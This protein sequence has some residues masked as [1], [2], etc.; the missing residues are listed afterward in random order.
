[1]LNLHELVRTL[2]RSTEGEG[3]RTYRGCWS[4]GGARARSGLNQVDAAANGDAEERVDGGRW[5][6]E[7]HVARKTMKMKRLRE[8][9]E[10]GPLALFIRRMDKWHAR[11]S[12]SSKLDM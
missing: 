9:S 7:E 12:R 5:A 4:G 10:K 6:R 1:M 11:E 8:E 3:G 2:M